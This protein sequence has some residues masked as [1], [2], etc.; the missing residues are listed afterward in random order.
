MNNHK[1][2][3]DRLRQVLKAQKLDAFIIPQGDMWNGEH[4]DLCDQRFQF[5]CGFD[6]SAGYVVVTYDKA[7]VLIDGRYTVQANK[8]IDPDVFD[9]GYYTKTSPIDYAISCLEEGN[10][11]GYD[12]WL[13][14]QSNVKTMQKKCDASGVILQPV[15][16]NPVD[17]I[18]DDRPAPVD[19]TAIHHDIQYSGRTCCDK[20]DDIALAMDNGAD[21]LIIAA[22]DSLSWV[23]N[24][25]TLDN[26]QSPTVKGFAILQKNTQT[27]TVYTN[28]DC[29]VFRHDETGVW[30]VNFS[31]LNK[32]ENDLRS[33]QKSVQISDQCPSAIFEFLDSDVIEKVDPCQMLKAVKHSVEQEGI[34]EAQRRDARAV[35]KTINW[36]KNTNQI[37]EID[38]KDKLIEERQINNNFR[39][40]SFDSIVGWNANGAAIHGA[41]TDT[42][43]EGDGL[44]LIDSGGQYDDGTTDIT[45]TVL[46]GTP[47]DDMCEKYTLVLKSHIAL[48]TAVFPQR[49]TGMELDAIA[50]QPL[51][52][53]GLDYA[54]GTGH[55][56]GHF[57]NVHEG[58]CGI[59]PRSDC[60]I[61]EG[62]YLSN[63]PGF[64]KEDHYGIRLENLVLVQKHNNND[65]WLCFETV[66]HVPFEDDLIIRDMMTKKELEWLDDYQSKSKD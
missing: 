48:A 31:L 8:Q 14:T 2:R 38:I 19:Q 58:P 4:P 55:G 22:P 63:E 11:V 13:H 5:I 40:V 61:K 62:M 23:L 30:D 56:V 59:S 10:V 66:T 27:I 15:A 52:D 21:N 12:P 42:M 32:F 39:G 24:L 9:I 20:L 34:R 65:G 46:I 35:K 17:A 1:D 49:V 53:Y 51:W 45:R 26:P 60:D 47:T 7:T 37:S 18:W 28:C 6:A 36:I 25:R 43:I 33:C 41:P 57:L 54:H 44:L 16:H 3:I 29:N 64:Y 50:R